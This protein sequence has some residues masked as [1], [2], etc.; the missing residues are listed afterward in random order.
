MQCAKCPGSLEPLRRD[1]LALDRCPACLGLFF[2]PGELTRVFEDGDPETLREEL[3]A[4]PVVADARPAACPRCRETMNRVASTRVPHVSYDVCLACNG[5][6]LDAGELAALDREH[7][8]RQSPADAVRSLA[9]SVQACFDEELAL[10]GRARDERL[11]RLLRLR[12]RGLLNAR[13]FKALQAR[14]ERAAG[15]ARDAALRSGVFQDLDRLRDEG[16]LTKAEHARMSR[17][18]LRSGR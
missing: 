10:I 1:G 17:A 7:S 2:D 13:A 4:L 3:C 12:R 11:G 5:I 18:A 14:V 15:K 9:A 6:W 16:I 8:G